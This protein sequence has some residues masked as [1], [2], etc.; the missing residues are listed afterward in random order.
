MGGGGE[1]GLGW[2]SKELDLVFSG[3]GRE[4]YQLSPR[5]SKGG[6]IDN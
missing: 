5:D 6:I 1:R 2:G 4:R 3:N